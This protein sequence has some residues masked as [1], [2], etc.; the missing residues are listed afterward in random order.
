[1]R[2]WGKSMKKK[3]DFPYQPGNNRKVQRTLPAVSH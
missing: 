2:G 1:M 3:M